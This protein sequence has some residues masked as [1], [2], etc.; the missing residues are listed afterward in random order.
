MDRTASAVEEVI[1]LACDAQR[2]VRDLLARRL[3]TNLD[4]LVAQR[5][6]VEEHADPV[7]ADRLEARR[8]FQSAGSAS[9]LIIASR[10]GE[11]TKT[12]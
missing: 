3:R 7:P 10:D 6:D 8:T 5:A 12:E 2:R 4:E 1:D 9:W 11:N